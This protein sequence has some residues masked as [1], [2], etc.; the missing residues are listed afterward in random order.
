MDYPEDSLM[1]EMAIEL[2][3]ILEV[4]ASHELNFPHNVGGVALVK[5]HLLDGHNL[6]RPPVNRLVHRTIG[7]TQR[8]KKKKKKRKKKRKKKKVKKKIL[9][10]GE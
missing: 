10:N 3:D 8:R 6:P 9:K 7:S 4:A 1:Q 5:E 2:N